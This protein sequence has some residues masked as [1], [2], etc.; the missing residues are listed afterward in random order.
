MA[1]FK[2]VKILLKDDG[3]VEVDQVGYKGKS[4]SGGVK[5]LIDA[6]GK[7]TKNVKK[8]EYYK[9]NEVHINQRF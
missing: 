9:E 1:S 5:D 7:D 8:P 6:I 2:T 4:C 3:T